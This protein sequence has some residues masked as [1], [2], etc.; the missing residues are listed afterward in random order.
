M[1]DNHVARLRRVLEYLVAALRL[2][3]GPAVALEPRDDRRAVHVCS[4]THYAAD[5]R[6]VGVGDPAREDSMG[7]TTRQARG[8]TPSGAATT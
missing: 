6:S 7:A 3:V 5:G 2:A 4:I 1:R 8:G